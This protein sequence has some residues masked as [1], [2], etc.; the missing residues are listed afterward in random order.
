MAKYIQNNSGELEE[1]IPTVTSS[2][3]PSA[4]TI[5]QLDGSGKLDLSLF[6][7]SL[8]PDQ[9][10]LPCSEAIT[11]GDQVNVYNVSGTGTVRKAIAT[12]LATKAHGYAL[13]TA[14]SGANVQVSFDDLNNLGTAL[15]PGEQFLSATTAGK[16]TTTAPSTSGQVVQKVG[17]ASSATTLHQSYGP[18]IK[19][20]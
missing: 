13:T 18:A 14:S 1:V 19:L 2:G 4:N 3:A 20:A 5:V 17:I 12:S 10:S 15:T 6:P 9:L 8:A 16:T 7:S 11:A